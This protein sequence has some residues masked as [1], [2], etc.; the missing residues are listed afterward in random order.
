MENTARSTFKWNIHQWKMLSKSWRK[1]SIT[2]FC[3]IRSKAILLDSD[4]GHVSVGPKTMARF[5]MSMRLNSLY[6]VTLQQN[7]M[8]MTCNIIN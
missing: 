1:Q 4:S 8:I 6:S 3:C 2:K 5:G 7:I